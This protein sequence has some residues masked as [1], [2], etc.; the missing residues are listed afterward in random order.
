MN[1]MLEVLRW[2]GDR[3]CYKLESAFDAD[4]G[5]AENSNVPCTAP[6]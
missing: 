2:T 1:A 4:R 3:R 5:V 6:S